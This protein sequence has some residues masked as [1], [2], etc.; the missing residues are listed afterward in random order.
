MKSIQLRVKQIHLK[1]VHTYIFLSVRLLE[2]EK[3]GV[4]TIFY[5]IIL[6]SARNL[7]CLEFG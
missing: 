2:K 3:N 1:C 6:F 7:K 5:S 4:E